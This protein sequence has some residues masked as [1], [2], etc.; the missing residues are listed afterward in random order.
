VSHLT[1]LGVQP[2]D[3]REYIFSAENEFG[4]DTVAVR[5]VVMDTTIMSQEILTAIIVGGVLTI[6]ILT[7]IIIYL[8]KAERCCGTATSSPGNAKNSAA[9]AAHLNDLGSDRTDVESCH[10]SNTASSSGS[11]SG[12]HSQSVLPPDALYGT[13]EKR[14][15]FE[16]HLFNDSKE[17]LRPDL[18]VGSH[19]SR[20]GSPYTTTATGGG[21]QAYC[22][23]SYGPRSVN[24]SMT[25][26]KKKSGGGSELRSQG[27]DCQLNTSSTTAYSSPAAGPADLLYA[28]SSKAPA[29]VTNMN[30]A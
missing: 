2:A 27:V 25:R 14:A 19:S 15:Y 13:V 24:G 30:Y 28:Y 22:G 20:G 8:V 12:G 16:H 29:Y 9:V 21:S 6:L 23:E 7:L 18:V 5:L 1:V 11:G 3:A 26:K 17:R 10:S 4:R